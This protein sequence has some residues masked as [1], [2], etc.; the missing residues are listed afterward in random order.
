MAT[1]RYVSES[2]T[3]HN[4]FSKNLESKKKKNISWRKI[5]FNVCEP[6]HVTAS[7]RK[8]AIRVNNIVTWYE[9]D[10]RLVEI[11]NQIY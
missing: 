9:C 3:F 6:V 2:E 10:Y 5:H 8:L 4:N 11:G 1:R 7:Y